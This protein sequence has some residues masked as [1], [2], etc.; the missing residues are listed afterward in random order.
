LITY[1]KV[2]KLV[3]RQLALVMPYMLEERMVLQKVEAETQVLKEKHQ[4]RYFYEQLRQI[5]G[6]EEGKK[7]KNRIRNLRMRL[8]GGVSFDD[9]E[10]FCSS[11][12]KTN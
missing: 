10:S 8:S 3:T 1:T 7:C 5:R 6:Q 12:E 9:D 11:D 4:A 2:P